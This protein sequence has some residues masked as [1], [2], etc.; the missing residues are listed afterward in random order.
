M[1]LADMGPNNAKETRSGCSKE[2]VF[3]L[4]VALQSCTYL[5]ATYVYLSGGE[6]KF[7]SNLSFIDACD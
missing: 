4:F 2:K 7:E 3:A 5:D 1:Y 6:S